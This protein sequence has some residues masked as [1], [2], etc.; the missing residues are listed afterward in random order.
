MCR[1]LRRRLAFLAAQVMA[2]PLALAFVGYHSSLIELTVS[3][4]R[5]YSL[6]FLLMGATYFAASMFTAVE[7]GK[8]SALISFVHTFVFE[9]GLVF[10]LPA[11]VGASGIWWSICVAEAA[12]AI[13]SLVVT[14]RLGRRYG[15]IT[16]KLWSCRVFRLKS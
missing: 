6:A 16:R 7:N 14:I 4:F 10:L 15:W 1:R 2:R 3:V 13:L 12:A 8:A 5:V 9:I 11:L